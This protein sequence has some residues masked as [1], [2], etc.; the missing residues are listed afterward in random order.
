[1]SNIYLLQGCGGKLVQEPSPLAQNGLK[2]LP[3]N[4][5]ND[6]LTATEV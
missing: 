3:S 5:T 2:I 4:P 1:M 6:E